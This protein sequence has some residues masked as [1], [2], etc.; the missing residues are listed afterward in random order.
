MSS[1]SRRLR[2]GRITFLMPERA[3]ATV[4]SLIPPTGNTRPRKTDL[5]C[6]CDIVLHRPLR[7]QRYQRRED[8]HAGAGSIL[9][10]C[11]GRDVN[12][13]IRFLEDQ[14]IDAQTLGLSLDQRQGRLRALLHDVAEL[15]GQD[16][17]AGA[18][19]AAAFDEQIY[20]RRRA[21]RPSPVA[22]PGTL[23][24]MATSFSK[25]GAPS[26]R[27]RSSLVTVIGPA[28]RRRS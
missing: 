20:L 15:T 1:R 2:A 10:Y 25:R 23:V 5:A 11:A 28:G 4:F 21:S 6:H 3:A 18:R 9:R 24:R 19:N 17:P 16:Q 22:T 7:Q 8:R 27:G 13:Q 26:M 14:R 12:V